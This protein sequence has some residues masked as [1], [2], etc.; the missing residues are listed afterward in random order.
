M[1]IIKTVGDEKI[2][3]V[4]IAKLNEEYIEFV[5]SINPSFEYKR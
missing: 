5:L 4:Y 3:K 2:S 1:E